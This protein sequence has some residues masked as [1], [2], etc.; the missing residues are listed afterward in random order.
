MV[1]VTSGGCSSASNSGRPLH[2]LVR[3]KLETAGRPPNHQKMETTLR[4][5]HLGCGSHKLPAPWENHDQ[6][7]D[8]RQRLPIDDGCAQF[9]FAEHVIE[10]V[11]FL[12]GIHFLTECHRALALGGVLRLSF[13]DMTRLNMPEAKLYM[14]YLQQIVR[15]RVPSIEEVWLS[16]ATDWG[17][18]S[19]WTADTATRLLGGVGF[20]AAVAPYGASRHAELHGIDGRHLSE[21]L[22]LA[23][24]ETTVVEA[25]RLP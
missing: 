14:Q 12:D 10:H 16:M 18:C 4:Y 23:R 1:D 11:P 24:A 7:V 13:P 8:I 3:H 2:A 15:R 9:I 22:E 19:V 6:E 5:L 20:S 25:T 21:G 17:H